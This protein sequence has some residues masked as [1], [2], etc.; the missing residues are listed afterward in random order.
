ME[1]DGVTEEGDVRESRKGTIVGDND[2]RGRIYSVER[3]GGTEQR[4]HKIDN[5][6]SSQQ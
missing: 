5:E 1:R 4:G 6:T 2:G 3:A